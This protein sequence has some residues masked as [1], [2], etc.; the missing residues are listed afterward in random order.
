MIYIEKNDSDITLTITKHQNMNKFNLSLVLI[1]NL[2]Q[3][4]TTISDLTD[5]SDVDLLIEFK[6]LTLPQN[7]SEGEYSYYV[8]D[9]NNTE[10]GLLIYGNYNANNIQYD[11]KISLKQYEG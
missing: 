10:V 7:L 1:N 11:K 9:G 8:S 5:S 6:N 4:V 3:E 2:T